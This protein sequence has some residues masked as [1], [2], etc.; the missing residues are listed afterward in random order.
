M[1]GILKASGPKPWDELTQEERAEV[2]RKAKE[3]I[4]KK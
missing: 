3:Q 2:I 1:S 4:A